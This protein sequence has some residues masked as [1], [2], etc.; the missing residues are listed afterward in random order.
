MFQYFHFILQ[1]H[2][3]L[4]QL[5]LILTINFI[6]IIFL[7]LNNLIAMYYR[8]CTKLY[9]H[10]IT[11]FLFLKKM[12][13]RNLFFYCLFLLHLQQHFSLFLIITHDEFII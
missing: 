1:L 8:F 11:V 5:L 6:I 7:N 2:F 9:F 3:N 10:F 12:N 4:M 13:F